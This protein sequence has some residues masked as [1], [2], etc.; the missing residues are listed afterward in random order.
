MSHSVE[1]LLQSEG[2]NVNKPD[3]F[4][5][6]PLQ[7]AA[8]QRNDDIMRLLINKKAKADIQDEYQINN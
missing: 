6:T 2:I 5:V 1:I 8:Y 4:G 3:N 7:I